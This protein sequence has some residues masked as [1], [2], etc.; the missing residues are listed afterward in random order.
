M[1]EA[2]NVCSA[3][4][5]TTCPWGCDACTGLA[6]F[7]CIQGLILNQNF[8]CQYRCMTPCATC[9]NNNPFSCLSCVQ[10]YSLVNGACQVDNSCSLDGTCMTCPAGFSFSANNDVLKINQVC[11]SCTASSNCARCMSSQPAVCTSCAFGMYLNGTICS[12]CASGCASCISLTMCTKCA[13]GF[14]AQ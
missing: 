10:G 2:N 6:C 9:A 12:S 11:T 14:V 7:S 5:G 8:Q 3:V 13:M 1:M 4:S